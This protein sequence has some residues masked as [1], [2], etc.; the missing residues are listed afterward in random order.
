MTLGPCGEYDIALPGT[1]L[2]LQIAREIDHQQWVTG[3]RCILGNIFADLGDFASARTEFETALALA[4]QIDSLYWIRSAAGWLAST[5]VRTGEIDAAA[6]VLANDLSDATPRDATA[7]RQLWC[8]AAELALAQGYP[9]RALDIAMRL[10]AS[11]PGMDRRPAARLEKLRGDALTAL[12]RYDEA[13]AAL[14]VAGEEAAWSGARPLLWRIETA[15]GRLH[16]AQDQHDEAAIAFDAARAIVADLAASVPEDT[17]RETFLDLMRREIPLALAQSAPEPSPI[18]L[19]PLTKREREIAGLLTEGLTNR[20]IGERLFVSEWTVATHV[21]N[22]LA[23]LELASRAQ[24]ASWAT[25]QGL[26]RDI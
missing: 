5:L 23:K 24:I 10:E 7:G 13:S 3:T 21:R 19:S 4:R 11:A 16:Q 22:I 12:G 18:E 2:A 14:S 6:A 15:R 25:S 1:R 26:R 20:E 9:S 8:A 17:L